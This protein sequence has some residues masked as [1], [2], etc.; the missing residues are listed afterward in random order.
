MVVGWTQAS[1]AR[2]CACSLCGT[3]WN[4]VRI[5]CTSCGATGGII[6]HH[7]EGETDTIGIESC[8]TCQ[9]YIKHLQQHADPQLDPLADD[10]ASYTLDLLAR[11]A[12]FSR[13]S[14]N[15]LFVQAS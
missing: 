2:Y 10:V 14:I 7:I 12:G 9:T 5:K 3:M 8:T 4:H 15:P 11:E 6:Y 13:S 1:K